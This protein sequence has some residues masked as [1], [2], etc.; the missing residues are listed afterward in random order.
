MTGGHVCIDIRGGG[1][2]A[3]LCPAAVVLIIDAVLLSARYR[4]PADPHALGGIHNARNTGRFDIAHTFAGTVIGGK[5]V[6]GGVQTA[7]RVGIGLAGDNVR[8]HIRGLGRVGDPRPAARGIAIHAVQLRAGD[9]VPADG[10]A[11]LVQGHVK[12]RRGNVIR[13]NAGLEITQKGVSGS[14]D[15]AHGVGIVL[16]GFDV[17]VKVRGRCG[18]HH[19]C[20]SARA[21]VVHTVLLGAGNGVPFEADAVLCIGRCQRRSGD[22]P[23][24][25]AGQVTAGER[26]ALG[27]D[28]AH[29]VGIGV[30]GA[31]V[32]IGE[33]GLGRIG[34]LCP[35]A[36]AIVVHTVILRSVDGIPTD[37]HALRAVRCRNDRRA[38]ELAAD[39]LAVEGADI[40]FVRVHTANGIHIGLSGRY[41]G[42]EER[43]L[44]RRTEP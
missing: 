7:H 35:S 28:T 19:L 13:R 12:I 18:I 3:E 39:A 44:G 4:L 34:Q 1:R 6:G 37:I 14:V 41:L 23:H 22:I 20:P 15:T 42:V 8:L 38:Q 2:V 24:A 43:G 21:V 27:V 16:A 30:V 32:G 36:R 33:S 40:I 11:L 17:L 5:G 9:R 25:L 26:R 31:D 10:N 29:G